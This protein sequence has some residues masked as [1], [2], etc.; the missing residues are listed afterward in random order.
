MIDIGS[1]LLEKNTSREYTLRA[2]QEKDGE[3]VFYL[4]ERHNKDIA[5]EILG[6][7]Q[8]CDKFYMTLGK[9]VKEVTAFF[10]N[11]RKNISR[12]NNTVY[13]LGGG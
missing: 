13:H 3:I 12:I 7:E 1:D 2:V 9:S 8:L 4:S 5:L 6:E 11:M 10:N